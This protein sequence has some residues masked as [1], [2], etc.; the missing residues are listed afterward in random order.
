MRYRSLVWCALLVDFPA[1]ASRIRASGILQ[2]GKSAGQGIQK[3]EPQVTSSSLQSV[4]RENF[5]DRDHRNLS[6]EMSSRTHL[7][8][9]GHDSF[10][11]KVGSQ[12]QMPALGGYSLATINWVLLWIIVGLLGCIGM[13]VVLPKMFAVFEFREGRPPL[14]VYCV[15]VASYVLLIPGITEMLFSCVF[16][17]KVGPVPIVVSEVHPGERG[18]VNLTTITLIQE[19]IEYNAY[20]AAVLVATWALVIP[21]AKLGLLLY[22]EAYRFSPDSSSRRAA[23][24]CVASV[25]AISKWA[26]PDM[27][28]YIMLM[29]LTRAIADNSQVL[30]S[31]SKLD[32]GFICFSL[33]CVLSTISSLAIPL[34]EALPEAKE[35][36]IV[37]R[38]TEPMMLRVL[39]HR[40]MQWGIVVLALAFCVL[41]I[42]GLIT[43]SLKLALD[44]ERMPDFPGK[45]AMAPVLG[46]S[47]NSEVSI[48]TCLRGLGTWLRAGEASCAVALLMLGGFVVLLSP[49]SMGALVVVTTAVA[50]GRPH[51]SADNGVTIARVVKHICMLDV[52]VVAMFVIMLAMRPYADVGLIVTLGHG[53]WWLLGAEAVHILTYVN[54]MNVV[55]YIEQE[56]QDFM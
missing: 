47:M 4:P 42:Q 9:T 14:W 2:Y 8:A 54:V 43:P 32:V 23:R 3:V 51:S 41:F 12:S 25:H 7:A 15:L 18:V 50:G 10:V 53:V 11:S 35:V 13:G 48:L 34:P 55:A 44:I 20:L 22:G 17:L 33:F 45:D 52:C 37:D 29:Y 56:K 19:L 36:D 31:E 6:F 30:Q 39:G 26:C 28:A 46:A 40:G 24:R 38:Q 16:V 5:A 49:L 27:F 21:V 1:N